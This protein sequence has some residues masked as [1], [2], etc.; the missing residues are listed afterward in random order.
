[1]EGISAQ[2]ERVKQGPMTLSYSLALINPKQGDSKKALNLSQQLEDYSGIGPVR[3]SRATAR[4]IIEFPSPDPVTPHAKMLAHFTKGPTVCLGFDRW[5]EPILL[6]LPSY[7]NL[8]VSGPPR[9]G[10]SSAMRSILYAAIKSANTK[11][12]VK[13]EFVIFAEKTEYWW[14]FTKVQGFAGI[15]ATREEANYGL[16]LVVSEM[17]ELVARREKFSPAKILVLDDLTS[18]LAGNSEL[19]DNLAALVTTGGSAGCYVL[20]GTQTVGS[21]AGTGGQSIED[22]ILARLIYR[23]SSRSAAARSTGGDSSAI[24]QLTLNK[25]DALL[26][27]GEQQTRIATGY[28]SD[29]DIV[30]DLPALMYAPRY[31]MG[32]VPEKP[33]KNKV[34]Q[35][36][37]YEPPIGIDLPSIKPARP[38][39]R[40]EAF[41]VRSWVADREGKG[42]RVSKRELL[43]AIFGGKN[44]KLTE[45][46]DKALGYEQEQVFEENLPQVA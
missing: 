6:P 32:K 34:V 19:V 12:T 30:S 18:L 10:K 1:M 17:R 36:V 25:G 42:L 43:F 27:L 33:V 24:D 14:A 41:I 44:A 20:I 9:S 39:T 13:A 15:F 21:R 35:E 38:L 29:Q 11:D 7:P 45:Y 37:E 40:E 23:T 3:V 8:L 16:N 46:L 5:G 2:V 22:S 26:V 4:L 31:T 28:V